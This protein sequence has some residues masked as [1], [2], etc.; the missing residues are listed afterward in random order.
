M[1]PPGEWYVWVARGEGVTFDPH[2]LDGQSQESRRRPVSTAHVLLALDSPD[3]L[4]RRKE[5]FEAVRWIG[6][7]TVLVRFRET[8]DELYVYSISATR[9]RL[10]TDV[11]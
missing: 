5:G 8:E 9:R 1:D 3:A 4:R 10:A 11:S 2:A 6:K 7:R